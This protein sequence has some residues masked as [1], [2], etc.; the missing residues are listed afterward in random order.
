MAQEFELFLPTKGACE[1]YGIP[2]FPKNYKEVGER[3]K[4]QNILSGITDL[5][6][7]PITNR[8]FLNGPQFNNKPGNILQ[9][10]GAAFSFGYY[11]GDLSKFVVSKENL[12]TGQFDG[13][14]ADA[15]REKLMNTFILEILSNQPYQI[16]NTVGT[17]NGP[18]N[19]QVVKT[20]YNYGG[21]N[22]PKVL[23]YIHIAPNTDINEGFGFDHQH[24][25]GQP[26]DIMTTVLSPVI[27]F[28]GGAAQVINQVSNISKTGFAG[29]VE[30]K[31][32]N[33]GNFE[34]QPLIK[35]DIADTYQ[36]TNK[37]EITIPFTLFTKR[38]FSR[39]ILTPIAALNAISYPKRKGGIES[40]IRDMLTNVAGTI[41][42]YNTDPNGIASSTLTT[43]SNQAKS[44]SDKL[45]TNPNDFFNSLSPGFRVIAA[46]PPSYINVTHSTNLINP[47]RNC[48]VTNF[49]Y[50]F[51]GPWINTEDSRV[52]AGSTINDSQVKF[53]EF[54]K[55]RK[56]ILDADFED[57]GIA[58]PL[59]AD[60]SIT[61]KMLDPMYSD[62]FLL[63]YASIQ[64]QYYNA[65]TD[66][67]VRNGIVSVGTK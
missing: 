13:A 3:A 24:S 7:D 28:I 16:K 55:A 47:M 48:V 6:N 10:A 56:D 49:S 34:T 32:G 41:D 42:R 52:K 51:K 15:G 20:E 5:I 21:N 54:W 40:I 11:G 22:K 14:D 26:Q 38:N 9:S 25:Y 62:D 33:G 29:L 31:N 53:W 67:V 1:D 65:E 64:D 59:R 17:T 60:C 12:Y 19:T 45:K 43:A 58:F 39:D 27:G 63:H 2:R 66:D 23:G 44:W 35:I 4:A 46:E 36:S 8:R 57:A 61:L 37:L 18:F 50:K 30:N